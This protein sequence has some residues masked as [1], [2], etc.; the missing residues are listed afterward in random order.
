MKEDKMIGYA[1]LATGIILIVFSIYSMYSVFTMAS[2][3]PPI[4]RMD[5][6]KIQ[7]TPPREGQPPSEIVLVP[8]DQASNVVNMMLW[9]LLMFFISS[10][11]AKIGG[12]G[13]KL[14]KEVKV[15]VK[16]GKGSTSSD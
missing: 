3:P 2:S 11:G 6:I 5:D 10:A 1:L 16:E 15:E 14:I 12:I 9:G 4:F 13:V 8:G 7:I